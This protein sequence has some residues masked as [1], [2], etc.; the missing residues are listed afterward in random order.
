MIQIEQLIETAM[1]S[2]VLA[3]PLY[4][5]YQLGAFIFG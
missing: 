5:V 4:L 3:A 1:G 2:A